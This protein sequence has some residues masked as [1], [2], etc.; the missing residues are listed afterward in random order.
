MN[1][2]RMQRTLYIYKFCVLVL[3]TTSKVSMKESIVLL[4]RKESAVSYIGK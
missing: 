2:L 4:S 1:K 3:H